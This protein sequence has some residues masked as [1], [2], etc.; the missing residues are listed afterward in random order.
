MEGNLITGLNRRKGKIFF[1]FLVCSFLAWF[2]S[3]LSDSYESRTNFTLNYKSLPDSLIL[4]N[5]ASKNLEAKVRTSGF[6][7]MYYRFFSKQIDVDLSNVGYQNGEYVIT[8][9]NLKKQ[10]DKQLS[11]NVSLLDLDRSR[12]VVDLYQVSQKALAIKPN[13]ELKFQP[14][15]ILDGVLTISPDSI[16]VKGPAS[17]IDTLFEVET[18]PIILNNLS[19]DFSEEASIVFPKGLDNSIFSSNRTQV[20]GHVVKFSEKVFEVEVKPV[21]FPDDYEVKMFPNTVSLV[22]KASLEQLKTLDP[23]SFEIIADYKQLGGNANNSLFLKVAKKPG[24]VY[25]VRLQQR[26]VNFVLE[27]K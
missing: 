3:N 21:N 9:D 5:K 8:E 18:E 2:L 10:M 17:E 16:V 4:G 26:T 14:N 24:T 6:Q 19:E 7:L 27:R 22:C 11:Q 1:L 12:W 13:I 23:G 20:S 15:H 25:A